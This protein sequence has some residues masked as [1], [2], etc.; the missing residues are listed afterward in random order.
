MVQ[1]RPFYDEEQCS[2]ATKHP[3][4]VEQSDHLVSFS[5][6]VPTEAALTHYTQGESKGEHPDNSVDGDDMF[7]SDIVARS[8]VRPE[9][10]SNSFIPGNNFI[11]SWCDRSA[12]QESSSPEP[13][14]PASFPLEYFSPERPT[15]TV[16]LH[17]DI[18]SLLL[19]YPPRKAVPIGSNHQA[20]IPEFVAHHSSTSSFSGAEASSEKDVAVG[21]QDDKRLMGTCVIPMPD[22]ELADEVG[23]ANADCSCLD[24]G[25]I[26]CVQQH[27]MEAREKLKRSIGQERF[28]ELGFCDMGEQVAANWSEEDEELFR[29]VVFSNP[30]SLGRNFWDHLSVVFPSRS[31]RDLVSYYFNVFMLR[32]RAEQNRCEQMKVDSD[33]DEWYGSEYEISEEHEDSDVESPLHEEDCAHSPTEKDN[34]A[35][36]DAMHDNDEDIAFA[37]GRNNTEFSESCPS[38]SLGNFDSNLIY[39]PNQTCW[40]VETDKEVRG[41][42]GPSNGISFSSRQNQEKAE[43]S[44]HF[45]NSKSASGGSDAEYALEP[46][47]AKVWDLGYLTCSKNK[48]S[49]LPT[50]S[51]IEEVFGD[52]S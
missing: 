8:T 41:E 21:D 27:I 49:F 47:D 12:G 30:V 17:E 40:G 44:G 14:V 43:A 48:I 2:V 5:E 18:Y 9:N 10:D 29:E 37:C 1:K 38:M 19:R 36:V 42:S 24:E 4:Q 33:N 20:H 28:A 26:R 51:M 31:K 16:A 32:R 22:L 45:P 50:C 34:E 35:T 23:I 13:P 39:H 52:E 11:S 6:F 7:E 3:R 46:C 15:R 25:S